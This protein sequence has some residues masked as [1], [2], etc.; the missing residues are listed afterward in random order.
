MKTLYI[1]R[2][3]KSSWDNPSL[4]D[5]ERPLNERGLKTAPF[6][7]EIMLKN[8]FKPELLLS[9]PAVRAKETVSLIKTSAKWQTKINFDERIYE[10]SPQTL[11]NIVGELDKKA[12]SA[13]IIGHNPGLEGLIKFITGE[14]QAMPTAGLA[15]ID[16][17]IED[18]NE[19]TPESGK[20]RTIV[21]PKEEIKS[22]ST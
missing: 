15:V 8:N 14:L 6:M 5:F 17:E 9:S 11:L 2:H 18:W 4:A 7:G 3:A 13:M 1:L 12:E 16:L 10:A 19:I 22:Q 21:R 20:L